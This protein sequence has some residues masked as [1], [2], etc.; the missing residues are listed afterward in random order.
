MANL[1][2]TLGIELEFTNA[3]SS[4]D[5]IQ[6][7][8]A[9]WDCGSDNC[10]LEIRCKNPLKTEEELY[11]SCNEILKHNKK[12][13]L[14]G[15]TAK[16]RGMHIHVGGLK[17]HRDMG[18]K[19][20]VFRALINLQP[21]FFAIVQPHANRAKWC[22]QLLEEEIRKMQ[23]GEAEL[24]FNSNSR[25]HWVNSQKVHSYGTYEFRIFNATKDPSEIVGWASVLHC[26]FEATIDK[27]YK[28]DWHKPATTRDEAIETFKSIVK[29]CDDSMM[30]EAAALHLAKLYE[31][32]AFTS[33]CLSNKPVAAPAL[34]EAEAVLEEPGWET[35]TVTLDHADLMSEPPVEVTP[36]L[37]T[38]PGILTPA[39]PAPLQPAVIEQLHAPTQ[40]PTST[41]FMSYPIAYTVTTANA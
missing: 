5:R 34:F 25:Y 40:A 20:R 32:P 11:T 17:G 28:A 23:N 21:A 13:N 10:M 26:L 8:L 16:T 12:L 29:L 31:E 37:T 1:K 3:A 7:H 30:K 6:T 38:A 9:N 41:T 14:V 33:L 2:Y 39:Q 19:Y 36:P 24:L 4:A 35:D 22:N 27:K 18:A 15:E